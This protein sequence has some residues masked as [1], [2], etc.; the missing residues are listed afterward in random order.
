MGDAA[1]FSTEE[2]QTLVYYFNRIPLAAVLR[3]FKAR[4]KGKRM[5]GDRLGD[6]KGN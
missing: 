5:E 6:Y 4:E 2:R 3:R 1:G